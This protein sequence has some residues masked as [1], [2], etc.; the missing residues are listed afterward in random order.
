MAL[1][2]LYTADVFTK[3]TQIDQLRCVF[4]KGD[5]FYQHNLIKSKHK[6]HITIKSLLM[7]FGL[8]ERSRILQE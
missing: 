8:K 3:L 1:L 6:F 5:I 4:M 2:A 7:I